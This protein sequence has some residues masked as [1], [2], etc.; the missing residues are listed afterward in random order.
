MKLASC[1][2]RVGAER[3]KVRSGAGERDGSRAKEGDRKKGIG[4]EQNGA[5]EGNRKKGIGA[6]VEERTHHEA[7]PRPSRRVRLDRDKTRTFTG[8]EREGDGT[9]DGVAGVGFEDGGGEVV[10]GPGGWAGAGLQ[11]H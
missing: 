1:G 2:E 7:I 10:G 4:M 8:V 5:K 6:E 3:G 11:D 9:H